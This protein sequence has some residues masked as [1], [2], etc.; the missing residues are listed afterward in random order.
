M[1][2]FNGKSGIRVDN[3]AHPHIILNKIYKNMEHGILLIE[4]SSATIEKNEVNCNVKINIG[5][6]GYKSNNTTIM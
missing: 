1:I 3:E 6:G 2:G 5:L 4:N